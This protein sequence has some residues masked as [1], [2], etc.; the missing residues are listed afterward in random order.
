MDEKR[1]HEK[2]VIVDDIRVENIS[3]EEV[4]VFD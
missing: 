4:G 1:I 2:K 3:D